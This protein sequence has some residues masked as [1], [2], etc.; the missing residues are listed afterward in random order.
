MPN[1]TF[2]IVVFHF[3]RKKIDNKLNLNYIKVG[4]RFILCEGK[5]KIIGEVL[6]I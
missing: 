3:S 2:K 5:T 6:T 1:N 4:T